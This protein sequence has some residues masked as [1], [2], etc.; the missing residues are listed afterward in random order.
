MIGIGGAMAEKLKH[1]GPSVPNALLERLQ[2][3]IQDRAFG[4]TRAN[5]QD[6]EQTTR[7]GKTRRDKRI[8]VPSSRVDR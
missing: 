2:I 7:T 8:G 5:G 6:Q 3:G 4:K 1:A